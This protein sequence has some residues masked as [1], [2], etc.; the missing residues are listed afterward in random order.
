MAR[1]YPKYLK[2]LTKGELNEHCQFCG[3]RIRGNHHPMESCTKKREEQM[4]AGMTADATG[5]RTPDYCPL[6]GQPIGKTHVC[7]S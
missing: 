2:D 6:C 1:K 7:E 5:T 3:A 4:E